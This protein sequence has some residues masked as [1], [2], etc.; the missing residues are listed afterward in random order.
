MY[1]CAVIKPSPLYPSMA[2]IDPRAFVNRPANKLQHA[3]GMAILLLARAL[4]IRH[5]IWFVVARARAILLSA[6]PSDKIGNGAFSSYSRANDKL[7]RWVYKKVWGV[8]RELLRGICWLWKNALGRLL[9]YVIVTRS[10]ISVQVQV[11]LDSC[12]SVH[13]TGFDYLDQFVWWA[14]AINYGQELYF[15]LY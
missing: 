11:S 6:A 7:P 1:A 12:L 13:D 8:L 9:T 4:V 2:G 15:D 3:P 5:L 14:F 10:N